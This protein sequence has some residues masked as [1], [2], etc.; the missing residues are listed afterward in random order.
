SHD[1]GITWLPQALV[2]ANFN[3]NLPSTIMKCDDLGHV[4]IAWRDSATSGY[5]H[6][7]TAVSEDFGESFLPN[8]K[9]DSQDDPYARALTVAAGCTGHVYIAWAGV[10]T[11]LNRSDDFGRTWLSTPIDVESPVY[12]SPTATVAAND[13][14][15]V[16][17]AYESERPD[18]RIWMNYSLDWGRT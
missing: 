3:D 4:Y 18:E 9:L 6:I 8:V 2:I 12:G 1:E 11:R 13:N 7:Y 17:V 14:G 5:N 15:E 16:F 10:P